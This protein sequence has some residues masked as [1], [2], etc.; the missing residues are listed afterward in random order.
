MLEL[1]NVTKRIVDDCGSLM[2]EVWD[3]LTKKYDASLGKGSSSNV[4]VGGYRRIEWLAREKD[5]VMKLHG[6]LQ[7]STACLSVLVAAAA[8]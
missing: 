4:F 5:K 8:Q 6:K 3:K 1:G 7:T 2:K